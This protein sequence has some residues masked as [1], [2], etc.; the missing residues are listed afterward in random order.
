MGQ[1]ILQAKKPGIEF[2]GAL[3][4][5]HDCI[6]MNTEYQ[7]TRAQGVKLWLLPRRGVGTI[8]PEKRGQAE[9]IL[10]QQSEG[11][12]ASDENARIERGAGVTAVE[13]RLQE[14]PES[15]PGGKQP[16]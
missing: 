12:Q 15:L 11:T 16:L 9:V 1:T 4:R 6:R 10:E 3:D 2:V 13:V 8:K 7:V 14:P 5:E